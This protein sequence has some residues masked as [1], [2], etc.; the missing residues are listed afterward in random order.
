MK[1][2][3]NS[4][5]YT[6]YHFWKANILIGLGVSGLDLALY[7]ITKMKIFIMNSGGIYPYALHMYLKIC[8]D[9]PAS[10]VN[11]WFLPIPINRWIM[12]YLV[13]LLSVLLAPETQGCMVVHLNYLYCSC[14]VLIKYVTGL[15]C[16]YYEGPFLP[17]IFYLIEKLF[18][19]CITAH[20]GFCSM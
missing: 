6:I 2:N 13:S 19:K 10:I 7:S 12:G 5:I 1:E 18:P 14:L 15:K 20:Y 8:L 11:H 16:F 9:R 3:R 17:I 4:T